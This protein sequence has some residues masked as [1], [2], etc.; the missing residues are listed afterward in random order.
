MHRQ[1]MLIL[2]TALSGAGFSQEVVIK[3]GFLTGEVYLKLD[4]VEQRA[5]SMGLVNGMLLAPFFDA[6]KAR[7]D[8]LE[9]C[10]TGMTD[11]QVTAL[12]LKYLRDNPSRWHETPH[13]PMF[14]AL[15]DACPK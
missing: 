3:T 5:Y 12:F 2:L 13:A 7:M 11:T 8:W 6:P 10:L 4:H 15:R 1:I 9:K 14:A